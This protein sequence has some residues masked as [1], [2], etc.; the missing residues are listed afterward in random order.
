LF[1]LIACTSII[2]V[3]G[4]D[5]ITDEEL[6]ALLNDEGA[7]EAWL[8]EE[9]TGWDL[10]SFARVGVGYSDNVLLATV[11]PQ[12]G[13]YVRSE[14]ELFLT[15]F[16]DDNGEFFSYLTG[17]DLRYSGVEDADKEQLWLFDT[18]WTRYVSDRIN[19]KFIAQYVFFN[20]IL[21][22]SLTERDVFRQKI[23]YHGYGLGTKWEYDARNTNV[24]S[25][26]FMGFKENYK[27]VLGQN[28]K[29]VLD[30][31][32]RRAVWKTSKIEVELTKDIRDH[33]DRVQRDQ[34]GRPVPGTH[35]ETDRNSGLIKFSTE[36]GKTRNIDSSFELKYLEN[37]DN[38][39]GYNDYDQWSLDTTLEGEWRGFEASLTLGVNQTEFI[40]QKAE[41]FG[42]EV[43]KREDI[44]GELFLKKMIM[45]RIS[46]Y[47]LLEYEDSQS[48]VVED[49]YDAFAG[50]LGFQ[51]DI[52]GEP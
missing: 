45:K 49:E 25:L 48:N 33:D 7:L 37:R 31:G 27:D 5:E 6:E 36:W 3:V 41:R 21:D 12:S 42:S 46:V 18:E 43:R 39:V 1:P 13:E 17:T 29:G 32:W 8:E 26:G 34:F 30:L 24:L 16:P 14:F 11:N 20:Q 38:G 9:F 4:Q 47:L 35:L 50:S 44:Y 2:S 52:W 15:R 23:E 22:L 51:L 10:S 28:L 40:I 19:A